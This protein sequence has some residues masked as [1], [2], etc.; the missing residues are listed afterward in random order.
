MHTPDFMPILS[1][2]AHPDPKEGAC[3][4]GEGYVAPNGYAR[5]GH[6]LLHREALARKLGRPVAA[7][8]D[9]CHTCDNR[10]CINPDHLYEG[11]RRQNMADC[12]ERGRHNK[13]R[14]ETHWSSTI[15]ADQ[16]REMRHLTE[17]GWTRKSLGEKYGINAA[18]VSRI[19][20]R[21]WRKEVA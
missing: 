7:G 3:V 6:V 17:Q 18:T 11:T 5:R 12:T 10:A 4:M 19:V 20:R 15:S 1:A 13:P 8:M 16:V 14:G 21:T 2:G 9:A